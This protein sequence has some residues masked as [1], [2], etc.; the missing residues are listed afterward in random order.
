MEVDDLVSL[1]ADER[2]DIEG[3]NSFSRIKRMSGS[4]QVYIR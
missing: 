4:L 1:S 2:H 3:G